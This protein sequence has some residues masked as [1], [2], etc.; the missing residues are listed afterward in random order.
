MNP[1]NRRTAA[2][3]AI[4]L[5]S[6]ALLVVSEPA[7]AAAPRSGVPP[8]CVLRHTA[9]GFDL[10]QICVFY[11]YQQCL[12]AAAG[13]YGNCVLNIDYHGK[14]VR[15]PGANWSPPPDWR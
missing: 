2:S 8:Y 6:A 3:V 13:W 4:L 15:P 5:C 12:E 9:R 10:P 11:D 14:L 7:P 1:D